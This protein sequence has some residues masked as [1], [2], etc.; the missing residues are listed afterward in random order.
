MSD[1]HFFFSDGGPHTELVCVCIFSLKKKIC[2]KRRKVF[3]A[4]KK[5]SPG[6]YSFGEYKTAVNEARRSFQTAKKKLL[7]K[8]IHIQ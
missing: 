8:P 4:R 6:G 5:E 3:G 1:R 7:N 2:Y